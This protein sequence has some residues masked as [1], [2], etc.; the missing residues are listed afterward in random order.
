[1]TLL[2][3]AEHIPYWQSFKSNFGILLQDNLDNAGNWNFDIFAFRR[4]TEG[5]LLL[6]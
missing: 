4:I 5:D 1:M 2:S 3:Y 6:L